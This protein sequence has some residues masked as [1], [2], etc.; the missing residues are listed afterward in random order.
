MEVTLIKEAGYDEALYGLSL[1]FKDREVGK[2]KWWTEARREKI[3]KVAG[4][5]AG[6]G[7]GHDKFLRQIV[8]WVDL[9]M[10]RYVWSEFDTYKVGVVASSEST[11][12]T[13]HKRW[14]T[15]KDFEDSTS[16]RAIEEFISCQH[17]LSGQGLTRAERTRR[18]K[19]CLPEGYLQRRLVTMNYASL[20]AIV[21]QR[22][23]H[24]LPEWQTFISQ[25]LTEI[26][27]PELIRT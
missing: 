18:M 27:H 20:Q 25:M 17:S 8:L 13:L 24:K 2:D 6:K 3:G 21:S 10:A 12:H 23:T 19:A 5:L 9:E 15:S 11:M 4:A 26:E 7:N 14:A 22:F 16:A 1:S